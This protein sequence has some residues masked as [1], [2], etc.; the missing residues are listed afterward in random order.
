MAGLGRELGEL[1][2]RELDRLAGEIAAYRS[3]DDL[4]STTGAQ[5][6]PPGTLAV[7]VVGGLNYFIAGVLGGAGGVREREREFAERGAPK[8]DVV[9]RVRSCREAVVPVLQSLDDATLEAPWP[10]QLPAQMAG[11]TTRTFLIHLLWHL[12]WHAGHVY[13]HR[14]GLE[15]G[16]SS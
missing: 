1:Y 9:R 5:K 6:N 8:D 15:G 4:W 3:D 2:A 7:H 13:Y 11:S 14:L 10:G 16:G 12:G